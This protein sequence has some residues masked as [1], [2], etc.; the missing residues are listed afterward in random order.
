[1]DI[2][3]ITGADIRTAVAVFA[4][5]IA[6]AISVL[7]LIGLIRKERERRDSPAKTMRDQINDHEK[8]IAKLEAASSANVIENRLM[9]RTLLALV[10]H[11][12]DGNNI[13][14]LR[15]IREEIQGYLLN[16]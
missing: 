7:S 14:G 12:I 15:D 2:S 6:L 10:R 4:I 1:M 3:N 16:K 8:R 13:E 11:S 5:L 9:M